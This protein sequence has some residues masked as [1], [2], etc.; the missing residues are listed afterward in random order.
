MESSKYLVLKPASLQAKVNEE[1]S[2]LVKKYDIKW[3]GP[4]FHFLKGQHR[5]SQYARQVATTNMR[6]ETVYRDLWRFFALTGEYES[7][8]LLLFP[9]ETEESK[10]CPAMR[11]KAC[12]NFL[13][14]KRNPKG[15]V[16][17]EGNTDTS[18]EVINVLTESA[19]LSE[20]NTYGAN[21][22]LDTAGSAIYNVHVTH[23][24][25]G[26]YVEACAACITVREEALANGDAVTPC[27][28]HKN[29]SRQGTWYRHGNPTR[30][31]DWKQNKSTLMDPNYEPNGCKYLDPADVRDLIDSLLAMNTIA[32]LKMIVMILV[33]IKI[34]LRADETVTIK[35]ESFLPSLFL[36]INGFIHAIGLGISG[37]SDQGKILYFNLW[38]DM[39]YPELCPLIH[40]LV[41]VYKAGIKGG[42]LFPSDNDLHNHQPT[43]GIYISGETYKQFL[44]AF[45]RL[46][47]TVLEQTT[48]GEGFRT[49]LHV[50]RKS[51]YCFRIAVMLS[52]IEVNYRLIEF[53]AHHA[54]N[55]KHTRT[56]IGDAEQHFTY[57]EILQN[58]RMR[59]SKNSKP[60]RIS[61][62][63]HAEKDCRRDSDATQLS[64][65]QLAE[66][67]IHSLPCGINAS[68]R[69][70]I[71][72]ARQSNPNTIEQTR[73][74]FMGSL[75]ENQLQWYH[76]LQVAQQSS[77]QQQW[78]NSD[79]QAT[80][81]S[82]P[83]AK[84]RKKDSR[85]KKEIDGR[86]DVMKLATLEARI[87][88]LLVVEEQC[89][90][91]ASLVPFSDSA[92]KW[93]KVTLR[94]ILRCY[95]NH[96][97]SDK[98]AFASAWKGK[99]FADFAKHCCKGAADEICSCAKV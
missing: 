63:V 46:A 27:T 36:R 56:Y 57:Q 7:M 23:D 14:W 85:N 37:K 3:E 1:L 41:Y 59:V 15:T 58:P 82:P 51:A 80:T 34:F 26:S 40:L 48:E 29:N 5:R 22:T 67:F 65:F 31:N 81:V 19:M 47:D 95:R 99:F 61:N 4:S 97:N 86:Q 89:P 62:L 38:R 64:L 71:I 8:L 32:G 50:F 84:K 70:T 68:I 69:E 17:R 52:G 25:G 78:N 18:D 91:N 88:K 75:S 74:N 77:Q 10:K 20:A 72:C 6:Y 79:D 33:S 44:E 55:S 93:A 76:L 28:Q 96:H 73:I 54:L 45:K 60:V 11:L 9:N 94:P 90:A 2:K 39:D 35:S 53:D 87:E 24:H 92:T 49:S 83:A 42:F 21:K 12:M 30:H 13:R 16:L 98:A 66:S 43:D